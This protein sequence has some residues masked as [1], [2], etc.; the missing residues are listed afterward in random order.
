[1]LSVF[2]P[3]KSALEE[4]KEELSELMTDDEPTLEFGAIYTATVCE[5]RPQGVM[6]KLYEHMTPVLLHNTQLDTRKVSTVY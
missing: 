2:A 4:A 1:M 5:L 3:N 6:V